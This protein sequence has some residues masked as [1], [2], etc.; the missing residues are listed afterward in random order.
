R[1][2]AGPDF[3]AAQ[4]APVNIQHRSAIRR[5]DRLKSRERRSGL[6]HE[7]L[8]LRSSRVHQVQSSS[9]S[10]VAAADQQRLAI[11]LPANAL[12]MRELGQKL[13]FVVRFQTA[14]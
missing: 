2:T 1:F 4:L 10:I 7:R 6:G 14:N 12:D 9:P 5:P 13:A 8:D 11:G 3:A